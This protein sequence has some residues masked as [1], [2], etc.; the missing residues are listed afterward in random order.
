[1]AWLGYI[2]SVSTLCVIGV[3]AALFGV[4]ES[5]Q[6]STHHHLNPRTHPRT[7]PRLV[8]PALESAAQVLLQRYPREAVPNLLMGMA[9]AE[10]GRLDEARGY[11]ETAMAIEPRDQQLLFLYARLLVDLKEDPERVREVVEQI[12]RYFP[13]SRDDVE[14]YFQQATEGAIRFDRSY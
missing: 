14:A 12:S 5:R 7:N 3:V 13:R 2:R 10:M 9:L 4:L 8:A 11:L 6:Q 1:M